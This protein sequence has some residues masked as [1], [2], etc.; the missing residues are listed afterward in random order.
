MVT[1]R[2]PQPRVGSVYVVS[3]PIPPDISAESNPPAAVGLPS[4]SPFTPEAVRD[5]GDAVR[6]HQPVAEIHVRR[7]LRHRRIGIVLIPAQRR[8]L[9]AKNVV[10]V[11]RPSPIIRIG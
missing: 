7:Y 5:H 3:K 6:L 8:A 10:E 1:V 2:F 11:Q 4:S 9:V